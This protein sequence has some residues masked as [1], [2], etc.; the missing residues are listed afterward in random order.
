[1]VLATTTSVLALRPFYDFYACVP[2]VGSRVEGLLFGARLS[3][4]GYHMRRR[5]SQ[6]EEGKQRSEN[7]NRERYASFYRN[8]ADPDHGIPLEMPQSRSSKTF[9]RTVGSITIAC[10]RE[11]CAPEQ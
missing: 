6:G 11:V 10:R 2:S 4:I 8:A 3:V 1:V 7:P 9:A 5:G